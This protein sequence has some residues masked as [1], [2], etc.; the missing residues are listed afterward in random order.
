MRCLTRYLILIAV[1]LAPAAAVAGVRVETVVEGLEQPWSLA[2][3]PDGTMLVTE[4][5]GRLRVIER[6]RLRAAPVEG[7]PAVYAAGQGGLLEVLPHPDFAGNRWLYLSYAHGAPEAN[8]LRVARA[9][10]DGERLFDL[11]VLLTL[12]PAKATP[13]H[14]GGRMAWLPDGSLLVAG[15]DGF[16]YRE[17]AQQL[18]SHLGKIL[19]IAA[20]GAVP[21]D[22]PFVD[23]DGARAEIYSLGHRNVQGL[24]VDADGS[25]YAHEHGPR[26]GDELNRIEAGG[27]YGWPLATHGVDYSGARVSPF[28]RYPNT[29]DPL[30]VWTPSIAPAGLARYSGSVHPAWA[31]RLLVT[32]LAGQALHVLRLDDGQVVE[33]ARLLSERQERLRDVRVG[34]DGMVYLLTDSAEGRVLRL[35]PE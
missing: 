27:N 8:A 25:V 34:P 30:H 6:D 4:R 1:C 31:G 17:Q 13:V 20:D 9:R 26:G 2:F 19:R 7:V 21:A 5:P 3:L 18:D 11:E 22:N 32:A 35:L 16:D 33:E 29:L 24:I 10:F 28:T 14:Y 23:R 12:A 15:G